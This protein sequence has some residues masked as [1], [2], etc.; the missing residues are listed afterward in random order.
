MDF[1]FLLHESQQTLDVADTVSPNPG[2]F[3]KL[4]LKTKDRVLRQAKLS[5]QSAKGLP[6]G[7]S[8]VHSI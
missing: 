2:D 8:K 5:P 3:S 1:I 4:N 6:V 7:N